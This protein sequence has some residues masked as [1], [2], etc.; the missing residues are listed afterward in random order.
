M[1]HFM[2]ASLPLSGLPQYP[3]FVGIL[4]HCLANSVTIGNSIPPLPVA[5]SFCTLRFLVVGLELWVAH[6]GLL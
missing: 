6:A 3:S 4:Q 2:R 5:V 1:L